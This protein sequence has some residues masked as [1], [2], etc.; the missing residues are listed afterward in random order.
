VKRGSTN[1]HLRKLISDLRK[2]S[3]P[4]WKRVAEDLE[5]SRR[6]RRVVN[7][8]RIN[9]YSKE[10]EVVVVPGKVLGDGVLEKKLDIAAFQFSQSAIEKIKNAGGNAMTI[11]ELLEKNPEGKGVKLLG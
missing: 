9:R 4:I 3:K 8:S 1:I 7:L 5:K 2:Q 10:G 6:N 11:K